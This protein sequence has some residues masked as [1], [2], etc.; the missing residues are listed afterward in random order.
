[1]TH[2]IAAVPGQPRHGG[3]LFRNVVHLGS[4][5]VV[6]TLLGF[7]L[8]AALGRFL[9][10]ADFGLFVTISMIWIFVY[11]AIDWGQATILI[12]EVAR[13]RQNEAS[14]LASALFMR[15]LGTLVALSVT[16]LICR[17]FG[18]D[19][20]IA[21]LAPL[22]VLIHLPWIIAQAYCYMFRARNRMDADATVSVATKGLILAA[23]LIV[24]G[25]GGGL[26]EVV[27]AQVAGT[28]GSLVLSLAYAKQIRIRLAAPSKS[29]CREL[30]IKG[31]PL[32]VLSCTVSLHP[33]IEVLLLSHLTTPEVVGWYGAARNINGLFMSP[34]LI[35]MAAS[36]P[37]LSRAAANLDEFRRILEQSGKVLLIAAAF[38]SAS[39]FFFADFG[40]TLIYGHSHFGPTSQL[41]RLG[42]VFLPIWF[43]GFLFGAG[44]N[45]FGRAGRLAVVKV[46]S[47]LVTAVASWMLVQNYQTHY[48]NGALA[49]VIT[50]GLSE[51]AMLVTSILLM[52]SGSVSRTAI[53]DFFKAYGIAATTVIALWPFQHSPIWLIAP[54]FGLVFIAVAMGFRLILPTHVTHLLNAARASNAPSAH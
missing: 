50:S 14:F 23:T 47:I 17:T 30:L 21:W 10:P 32:A 46:L 7:A 26:T 2:D 36:F 42:A 41:L 11:V 43:A 24:L 45:A 35:L 6:S 9:G 49:L 29:I 19:S 27:W 31:T 8:T 3:L 13:G 28:V 5:Q 33:F 16:V 22:T 15:M 20:R 38:A 48:N 51:I 54:I 4:A 44:V 39:L 25:L 1:M 52:P 37:A 18:F 40:V 53:I 12:R 34:A